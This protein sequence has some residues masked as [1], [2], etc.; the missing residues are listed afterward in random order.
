VSSRRR[1]RRR[2]CA[3]KRRYPSQVLAAKAAQA[4]QARTPAPSGSPLHA[5]P[6]GFCAG[7]HIGHRRPPDLHDQQGA[8][9]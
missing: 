8:C 7:W 6:C 1:L 5:Y 3:R 9:P 2:S 4:V